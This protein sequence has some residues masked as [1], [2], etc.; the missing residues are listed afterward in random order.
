MK[1]VTFC[2]RVLA[3]P[4]LCT[5]KLMP[6]LQHILTIPSRFLPHSVDGMNEETGLEAGS[7]QED[8]HYYHSDP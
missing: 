2:R 6:L 1:G 4:L 8:V 7:V 3:T 5:L